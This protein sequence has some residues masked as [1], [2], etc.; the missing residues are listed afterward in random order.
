ML[1]GD[2][3]EASAAE[4]VEDDLRGF[5]VVD[6]STLHDAAATAADLVEDLN[7]F[8]EAFEGAAVARDQCLRVIAHEVFDE[9]E[10]ELVNVQDLVVD[11]ADEGQIQADDLALKLR[12]GDTR[13]VEQLQLFIDIDPLITTGDARLVSGLR[14]GLS[15]IG[16]DE[17]GLADV[18]HT[19]NHRTDDRGLDAAL[20]VLL[21]ERLRRLIDERI[22]LLQAAL[23]SRIDFECIVAAGGEVVCEALRLTTIREIRLI[24]KE[25]AGLILREAVDVR[26]TGGFRAAGVDDLDDEIDQLQV[27][28]DVSFCF[29]H[30]AWIPL[31]R[32]N[33]PV[34]Y[35]SYMYITLHHWM[36]LIFLNGSSRNQMHFKLRMQWAASSDETDL[37]KRQQPEPDASEDL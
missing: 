6:V 20:Q 36:K 33:S 7:R 30:M 8:L 4:V 13:G 10:Y 26:I 3:A 17:G 2:G 28:T 21:D 14:H 37:F 24:D 16:I 1:E 15:D 34:F 25:D 32:H 11:G 31:N 35:T 12:P 27:L 22:Q 23:V 29:G 9:V 19:E 5:R 18:R